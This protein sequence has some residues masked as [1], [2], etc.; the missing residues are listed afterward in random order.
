M[1]ACIES[2]GMAIEVQALDIKIVAAVMVVRWKT[3]K[4][5]YY[6]YFHINQ[7]IVSNS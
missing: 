5:Y 1:R 4:Y 3:L 6:K 7:L 2:S